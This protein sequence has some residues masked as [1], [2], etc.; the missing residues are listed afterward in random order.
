LRAPLPLRYDDRVP[1]K[2]P[3]SQ[4]HSV[5]KFHFFIFGPPPEGEFPVLIGPY[6]FP[7][8]PVQIPV[9][10]IAVGQDRFGKG[11][12]PQKAYAAPDGERFLR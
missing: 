10:A 9:V 7:D 1:E 4:G 2:T 3:A 11:L 5:G 6:L 8:F 12:V